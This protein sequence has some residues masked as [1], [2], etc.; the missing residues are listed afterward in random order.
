MKQSIITPISPLLLKE[1]FLDKVFGQ[2]RTAKDTYDLINVSVEI[3]V[4]LYDGNKAVCDDSNVDLYAHS[5]LST[6]PKGLNLLKFPTF[7]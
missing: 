7:P 5:I 6:F 2:Q 4:V 3:E 1:Y